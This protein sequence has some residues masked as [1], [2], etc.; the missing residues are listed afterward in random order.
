MERLQKYLAR[1]GVASR[2]SAEAM[3]SAGR[4]MVNGAIASLGT[5][6]EPGQDSVSV[7]GRVLEVQTKRVY[8]ALNKPVGTVSTTRDPW[9]RPTVV[10]LS[11][12]DER[13]YPVGRLDADSEGLI[14][15]TNDGELAHRLMHPRFGCTK[16]YHA[17]LA[18]RP[19]PDALA[20]LR[21]GIMLADGPTAPAEVELLEHLPDGRV[22]LRIVLREGRNRQ[23]RRMLAAVGHEVQLLRRVRVGSVELGSLTAGASRPLSEAEVGALRAAVAVAV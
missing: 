4:V 19:T 22:W 16:E 6:I 10:E 20:R 23:I 17:L 11:P 7:D 13:L 8:I 5:K 12:G 15:L 18:K 9:G 21:Q 14:L 2:R 3:I 1:H